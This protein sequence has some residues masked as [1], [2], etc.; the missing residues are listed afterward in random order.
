M[1]LLVFL[2]SVGIAQ[3]ELSVLL[4]DRASAMV[5]RQFGPIV[6]TVVIDNRNVYDTDQPK[7]DYLLFRWANR[8]HVRTRPGVI[9][10]ELLFEAGQPYPYELA[11]ES[12]RNI[13]NRLPVYDA[14]IET[15]TLSNGHLRVTVVTIDEW[16]LGIGPSI[17]RDGNR[18]R[19]EL[20][21]TDRN[22]FGRA[23]ELSITFVG[24]EDDD[25]FFDLSFYDYRFGSGR[26]TSILRYTDNPK[27][28]VKSIIFGRPFFSLSQ[29]VSYTMSVARLDGRR[30]IYS[31]ENLIAQSSYRADRFDAYVS[32]RTGTY[33]RKLQL[34][35][36]YLYRYETVSDRELFSSDSGDID[37]ANNSFPNDSLYHQLQLGLQASNVNYTKMRRVDGF[38]YIEDFTLG[39]GASITYGRAFTPDFD[40][41]LFEK[42]GLRLAQGYQIGPNLVYVDYSRSFWFRGGEK[43]RH[44]SDLTAT[45]YSRRKGWVTLAARARYRS[46]DRAG[47]IDALVLGGDTGLRGYDRYFRT[48]DRTAIANV[49]ARIFPGFQVHSALVSAVVFGDFGQAWR[50][51]E[52]VSLDHVYAGVGAGIRIGLE[53]SARAKLLRFDVAYSK[54][55]G[56]QLSIGTSHYFQASSAAFLLT[57]P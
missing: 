20:A 43:I 41:H 52:P 13:R 8:I 42:V 6:D 33:H 11:E 28:G 3:A 56:W 40:D 9:R 25:D 49:E 5:A 46:D 19:Y 38:T 29:A 12:A 26:Y 53:H 23:Q 36:G 7:F 2:G 44:Y 55:A 14:W 27:D 17:K 57:S 16:T 10:R 15:D 37:L 45:I 47:D 4:T 54:A 30:E 31:N 39:Q 32:T 24:Q 22:L 48:G 18:L 51:K 34:N 35:A 50:A 1:L 21:A